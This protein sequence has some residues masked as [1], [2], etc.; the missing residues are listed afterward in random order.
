MPA[1]TVSPAARA[2]LVDIWKYTATT[3]NA[4]EADAYLDSLEGGIERLNVYPKL[5]IDYGHVLP[6]YRRL[7]I[8]R[9]GVFYKILEQEVLVVRILHEEMDAPR[10]IGS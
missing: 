5:G 2:D 6:G 4:E 8:E 3:W 10:H 9:H 7:H 1:I